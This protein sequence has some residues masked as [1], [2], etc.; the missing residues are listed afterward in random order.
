[1]SFL[2]CTVENAKERAA[3]LEKENKELVANNQQLESNIKVLQETINTNKSEFEV[4]L[5]SHYF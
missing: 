4:Q 3:T 1:L 2:L 5:T